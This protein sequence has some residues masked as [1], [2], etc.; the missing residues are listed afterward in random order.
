MEEEHEDN[1]EMS[2]GDSAG[3]HTAPT[4]PALQQP[5]RVQS[6]LHRRLL[7]EASNLIHNEVFRAKTRSQRS[8]Q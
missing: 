8:P 2:D 1:A 7:R 5:Q 4:S 6:P 3:F